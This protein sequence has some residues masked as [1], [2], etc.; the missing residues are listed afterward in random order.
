ME[1]I[2]AAALDKL[3]GPL[4]VPAVGLP[5]PLVTCD[6]YLCHPLQYLLVRLYLSTYTLACALASNY[7]HLPSTELPAHPPI[8]LL[9]T[10]L[11]SL[12]IHLPLPLTYLPTTHLPFHPLTC[13]ITYLS[14]FLFELLAELST[15]LDL[16]FFR[17]MSVCVPGNFLRSHL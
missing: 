6:L 14:L 13:F 11:L 1:K 3:D 7:L 15:R 9:P 17:S 16:S 10:Y 8:Y 5:V 2:L 12:L 4:K